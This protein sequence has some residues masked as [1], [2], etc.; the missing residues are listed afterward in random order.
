MFTALSNDQMAYETDLAFVVI[1]S[2]KMV[3]WYVYVVLVHRQIN[4]IMQMFHTQTPQIIIL[5]AKRYIV[6]DHFHNHVARIGS[7]MHQYEHT[8]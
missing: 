6:D 1:N 3:W 2:I 8:R 4:S 5:G 7:K